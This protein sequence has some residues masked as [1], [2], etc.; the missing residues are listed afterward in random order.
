MPR[1][2]VYPV[3]ASNGYVV[4]VQADLLSHL[5][6]RIAV[7][8]LPESKAPKPITELNPVFDIAGEPHVLVTQALASVPKR[9]LKR[10]A[11]SLAQHQEQ[12]TRALDL[13]LTGY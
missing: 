7:P 10:A 11:W 8:L 1:F 5:S 9:E 3:A 12:V 6:T 2:D 13:L 4:D